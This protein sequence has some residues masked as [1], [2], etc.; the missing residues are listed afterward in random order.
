[1][2]LRF[3]RTS[4]V[5]WVVCTLALS[6]V[7]GAATG[8]SSPDSPVQRNEY[9]DVLARALCATSASA[10]IAGTGSGLREFLWG[11]GI[12]ESHVEVQTFRRPGSQPVTIEQAAAR[13]RAFATGLHFAGY[14]GGVCADGSGFAVAMPATAGLVARRDVM[15]LP[16]GALEKRCASVR[17]DF[18]PAKGGAPRPVERVGA[19]FSRTKLGDG[20]V[21]VTCNTKSPQW[22]GPVSWFA[23][24]VGAGPT[25]HVPEFKRL[26]LADDSAAGLRDWIN[27]LRVAEGLPA[28]YA[29]DPDLDALADRLAAGSQATHDRRA[30]Q[31]EQRKFDS[32]GKIIRLIGED[33]V[34]A[35][36]LQEAA[37]LLWNSP[38][39]RG[40]LT[41]SSATHVGVHVRRADDGV[42]VVL[43]TANG[44]RPD[45]SSRQA[46]SQKSR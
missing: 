14:V 21:T 12:F 26:E 10:S 6:G 25:S 44:R 7:V 31:R 19:G 11:A 27:A 30:M 22:L 43:V 37:W 5:A 20:V 24:P 1:M 36:D 23:V 38:T 8:L 13:A 39:H 9:R 3:S 28:T 4:W 35:G 2:M 33:R 42:F 15:E 46:T 17:L 18:A 16:A 32:L 34:R 29:A 45:I 40:L 41:D